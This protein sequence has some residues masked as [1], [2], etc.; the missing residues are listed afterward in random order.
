M[1]SERKSAPP[2]ALAETANA[3]EKLPATVWW[4][5]QYTT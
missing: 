1:E 4:R 2:G 5:F 3:M